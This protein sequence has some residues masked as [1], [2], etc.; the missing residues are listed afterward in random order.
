M[1]LENLGPLMDE[2][3]AVLHGKD[4]PCARSLSPTPPW[5]RRMPSIL[6]PPA[7]RVTLQA[8]PSPTRG[9]QASRQ[10]RNRANL[11][12]GFPLMARTPQE[13]RAFEGAIPGGRRTATKN[14]IERR[15]ESVTRRRDV[16]R[17]A[18]LSCMG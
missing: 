2:L 6:A 18:A 11:A 14:A 7:G 9:L 13:G 1:T 4:A 5:R 8:L 3:C 15:A 16:R 12:P 17:S 10:R